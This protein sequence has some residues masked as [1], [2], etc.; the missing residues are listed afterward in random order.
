MNQEG[1]KRVHV[2]S[3]S[4]DRVLRSDAS[5]QLVKVNLGVRAFEKTKVNYDD[6]EIFRITQ[7]G[8]ECLFSLVADFRKL[9]VTLKDLIFLVHN[10]TIKFANIPQS[11]KSLHELAKNAPGFYIIYTS[12][13]DIDSEVMTIQIFTTSVCLMTDKDRCQS[14]LIKHC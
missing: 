8:A 10:N 13:E 1:S 9:P 12:D 6:K 4:I 14:I 11:H 3:H 2:C 5:G 7:E